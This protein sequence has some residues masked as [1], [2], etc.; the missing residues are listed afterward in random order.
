MG[1]EPMVSAL[2]MRCFTA[3]LRQRDRGPGA[4]AAR[5]GG[6]RREIRFAPQTYLLGP[7][8][9][10][11]R[12]LR[13][14]TAT[15]ALARGFGREG[16]PRNV[17]FSTLNATP[18]DSNTAERVPQDRAL[19]SLHDEPIISADACRVGTRGHWV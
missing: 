5:R 19:P 7:E 14:P 17:P 9:V 2:P 4:E 16:N 6:Q 13:K 1:L 15:L 18:S 8:H 12:T 10:E 11:E 3:K